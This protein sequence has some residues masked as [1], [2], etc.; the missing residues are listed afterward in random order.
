MATTNSFVSENTLGENEPLIGLSANP[1]YYGNVP[2]VLNEL[3]YLLSGTRHLSPSRFGLRILLDPHDRVP[4]KHECNL[5]RTLRSYRT[6]EKRLLTQPCCPLKYPHR[7]AST[8]KSGRRNSGSD[9]GVH[10]WPRGDIFPVDPSDAS[11]NSQRFRNLDTVVFRP[12][13]TPLALRLRSREHPQSA[14]P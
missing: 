14:T 12:C 1:R 7:S 10:R 4:V 3:H 5:P 6:P 8:H 11:G 9:M 2:A 13:S